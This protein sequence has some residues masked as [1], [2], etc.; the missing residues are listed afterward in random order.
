[1]LLV[2]SEI[3]T[4]HGDEQGTVGFHEPA[5][6]TG[7]EPTAVAPVGTRAMVERIVVAR[8][9]AREYW[10]SLR[11][12]STVL[13]RIAIYIRVQDKVGR[14]FDQSVHIWLQRLGF[15]RISPV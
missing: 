13:L 3:R 15:C 10:I 12:E 2:I 8:K 14:I 5:L 4:I 9:T 7:K 6:S 1:M 11:G